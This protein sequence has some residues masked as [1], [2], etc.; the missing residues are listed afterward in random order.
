MTKAVVLVLVMSVACVGQTT[1]AATPSAGAASAPA[2]AARLVNSGIVDFKLP[3]EPATAGCNVCFSNLGGIAAGSDG[4]MW[5]F[6]AGMNNL[7]R[8]TP[9][10]SVTW[11]SIPGAGNG[12]RSIVQGPDGNVWMAAQTELAAQGWILRITPSGEVTKYPAGDSGQPGQGTGPDGIAAGPDGNLWFTEEFTNR[13][14]R[15][16]PQG[17]LTEFKVPGSDTTPHGI[18]NG[19]DGS[20][21]FTESGTGHFFIG[22]ITTSG[23]IAMFPVTTDNANLDPASIIAG[24]DHN[25]WFSG[26]GEIDRM[27]TSGV[28]T[29]FKGVDEAGGSDLTA[30]ADGHIW[31]ADTDKNAIGRIDMGGRVR[32]FGLP[33]QPAK[34]VG[35][36]AGPGGRIWFTEADAR[37]VGNIGLTV[38]EV[39]LSSRVVHFGVATQTV[40]VT[41]VGDGP[42]HITSVQVTGADSEAFMVLGDSCSRKTIA[43]GSTCEVRVSHRGGSGSVF[44]AARLEI[45]DNATGSPHDV[46]LL[47]QLSPCR[48]PIVEFT[49]LQGAF[50]A[51]FLQL[52]DGTFA[53]DSAVDPSTLTYERQADKWLPV[54]ESWVSPDGKQYVNVSRVGRGDIQLHVVDVASGA[55]RSVGKAGVYE[56]IA[57][58]REGIYVHVP[59]A[60][61]PGLWLVDPSTGNVRQLQLVDIV[62][63]IGQDATWIGVVNPQDPHP[64]ASAFGSKAPDE[65]DRSDLA[66]G[67]RATWFY[68]PGESL[69]VDTIS[70]GKL[71]VAAAVDF[72]SFPEYWIVSSPTEAD[73]LTVPGTDRPLWAVGGMVADTNGYWLGTTDGVYLW[74]SGTGAVLVGDSGPSRVAGACA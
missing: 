31:F 63:A 18:A 55:D 74:T 39:K 20:L 29:R 60:A 71:L 48:L 9:T 67:Q 17:Q 28:I 27:T 65:I 57:F 38:P 12:S 23:V 49:V 64:A 54:P 24:P 2:V 25:L 13:I 42:L 43:V 61:S 52:G 21:W 44:Q 19:P 50:A 8:I 34:P 7:G 14:G 5:F 15:I 11:F 51:G 70:G 3:P 66:T 68:R 36:A 37:R 35:I 47:A 59:I 6:D 41:S 56:P 4:N 16:T 33:T 73:S 53:Q 58:G 72:A 46:S 62:E 22:R 30:G 26:L 1:V 69:N 45:L 32:E 10:G 40:T